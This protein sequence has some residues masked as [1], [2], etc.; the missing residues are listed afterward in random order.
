[1]AVYWWSRQQTDDWWISDWI[2]KD[3]LSSDNTKNSPE[4]DEKNFNL[5]KVKMYEQMKGLHHEAKHKL[6]LHLQI[7]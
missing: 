3:A 6:M 7:A 4:N 5:F 2:F 1:M